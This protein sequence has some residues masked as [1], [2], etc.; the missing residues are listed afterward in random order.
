MVLKC[1]LCVSH[2]PFEKTGFGQF[3]LLED[4]VLLKG[5]MLEFS[6]WE[7]WWS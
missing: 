7:V 6:L 2:L 3:S 5:L 1:H 4:I